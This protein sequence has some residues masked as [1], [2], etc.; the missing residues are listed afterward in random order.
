MMSAESHPAA[1]EPDP[2]TAGYQRWSKL[3]FLHWRVD[4]ASLQSHI[5]SELRIQQFDGSAWLGI[6]PFSMERIRPWWA[7]PVP[8]ISWFLETNIRTYVVDKDGTPGVWFF[9]LDCNSRIAVS[10]ACRFW[11]L[12]YKLAS[13]SLDYQ[14]KVN[15][16]PHNRIVYR[17][18]RRGLSAPQYDISLTL[19]SVRAT[20]AR[21]GTLEYFLVERYLLFA[22]D[23]KQRL[24]TGRVHHSP[25][26]LI[27]PAA[28]TGTQS[29]TSAIAKHDPD[30]ST[31][32]HVAYCSGVDVRISPLRLV[33]SKCQ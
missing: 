14:S 25:Y 6:V 18:V 31:A 22:K 12:P 24:R 4:A 26:Q 11:H 28:I 16:Q 21:P 13:M 2:R 5:P 32:D 33:T 15:D 19:P 9:T 27:T 3:T 8:G 10:L 30:V 1:S 7:P 17:G 20:L 23:N 29:L